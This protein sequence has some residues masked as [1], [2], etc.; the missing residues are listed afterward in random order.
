MFLQHRPISSVAILLTTPLTFAA[1]S[2]A[3]L[4]APASSYHSSSTQS[5]RKL[6]P[7]KVGP[8]KPP[9]GPSDE[10]DE[11]D[12]SHESDEA[13]NHSPKNIY[14]EVQC[15]WWQRIAVDNDEDSSGGL[16][17]EEYFAFLNVISLDH[18]EDDGGEDATWQNLFYEL[19]KPEP[20]DGGTIFQV[21]TEGLFN[22]SE[23]EVVDPNTE[24]ENEK[25]QEKFCKS[26][27]KGL[28]Q[29][30]VDEAT[31]DLAIF[32]DGLFEDPPVK[33]KPAEMETTT[34]TSSSTSAAAAEVIETSV[35]TVATI[36]T[37]AAS[38]TTASIPTTII[39]TSS[40]TATKATTLLS[41]SSSTTSTIS[42]T[43]TTSGTTTTTAAT[44]TSNRTPSPE[45]TP[46]TST[47][48]EATEPAE[49]TTTTT[50]TRTAAPTSAVNGDEKVDESGSLS[51]LND[52]TI[53]TTFS[54]T[55]PSIST[56][57]ALTKFPIT[58]VASM[59]S[60][61]F[62]NTDTTNATTII[63]TLTTTTTAATSRHGGLPSE[64]DKVI[65]VSA[66]VEQAMVRSDEIDD[67]NE[68]SRSN[69][70]STG[71]IMGVI[72]GLAVVVVLIV[73]MVTRH[74]FFD[75]GSRER[76]NY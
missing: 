61:S 43:T 68:E 8:P 23:N 36:N 9:G 19:A 26:V 42:A 71:V 13:S 59:T 63:A 31:M 73:T 75:P 45:A 12:D 15:N 64:L 53:A 74:P 18:F 62:N 1:T 4:G 44:T 22:Y 6:P 34:L 70:P 27:F 41:S 58:T 28:L 25:P 37:D 3:R 5:Q 54:S 49:T 32:M 56:E 66:A 10:T 60:S 21:S 72:C 39:M 29:E 57:S 46:F 30:G 38:A 17:R 40:T 24:E 76:N 47:T 2:A 14:T 55:T 20:V 50:T 51:E 69:R 11:L 65:K 67:L 52:S 7:G 48:M 16:D 35:A 33:P